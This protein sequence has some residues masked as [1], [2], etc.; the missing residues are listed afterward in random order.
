MKNSH[1]M[2]QMRNK[3]Q[4]QTSAHVFFFVLFMQYRFLQNKIEILQNKKVFF[5]RRHLRTLVHFLKHGGL[6]VIKRLWQWN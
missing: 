2:I 3:T 1:K 5:E 4:A 6:N